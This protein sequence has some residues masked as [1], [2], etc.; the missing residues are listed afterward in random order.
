MNMVG[1]RSS[2]TVV[3]RVSKCFEM[4]DFRTFLGRHAGIHK[5]KTLLENLSSFKFPKLHLVTFATWQV[6]KIASWFRRLSYSRDFEAT[7][8]A[9]Y[10]LTRLLARKTFSRLIAL[11]HAAGRRDTR[12]QF[13]KYWRFRYKTHAES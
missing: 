12:Q 9:S 11:P 4:A 7:E 5:K 13:N 10:R 6:Y 3:W 1:D 2:Q 8:Q